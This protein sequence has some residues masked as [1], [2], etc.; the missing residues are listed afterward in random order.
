MKRLRGGPWFAAGVIVG[1]IVMTAFLAVQDAREGW[2]YSRHHGHADETAVVNRASETAGAAPD[3]AARAIVTLDSAQFDRLGVQLEPARLETVSAETRHV[4]TV[5]ADES[6]IAHVHT[7]VSGWVEQ[8][9]VNTTGEN[10]RAGQPLAAVFSQDL[11]SS[12]TEYLTAL[13]RSSALQS[14]AVVEAARTRL[15]VLGM[16]EAEIAA[17]ERD[18]TA[19]RLVTVVAP[20][21]GVVLRRGVTVGTAIDPSTELMTIADLSRVWVIA[22]VALADAV[23]LE[24]GSEAQLSFPTLGV[25]PLSAAVDFVYPTLSERT[26]TVRMRF[27][28]PNV[29]HALRPGVFGTATFN[30]TARQALTVPRDSIVE[31]GESQHVF[32]HSEADRLEPRKVRTGAR[33]GGRVEVVEG[34]AAGEHVVSAGV[35]LID[36]ESRLRASSS[37]VGHVGH[38]GSPRT[39]AASEGEVG[40]DASHSAHGP[41]EPEP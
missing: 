31:T 26:R 39:S 7:R 41:R 12:Q 8:L 6:R 11:F 10:V 27:S 24:V 35:F 30:P 34:L 37:G 16:E 15:K 3:R 32:V 14:T 1:V 21:S 22:E 28:V 13:G 38:G 9:Y 18:R 17:L 36:S 5:T 25:A 40:G 20:R 33:L 2:P 29:D 4:A 19:R 23:Q